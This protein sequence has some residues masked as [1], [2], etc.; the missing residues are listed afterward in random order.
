MNEIMLDTWVAQKLAK[1]WSPVAKAAK[2]V[3]TVLHKNRRVFAG[4]GMVLLIVALLAASF[5]PALADKGGNGN[6]GGKPTQGSGGGGGGQR[7][8]NGGGVGSN[9][10]G[11][12]PCSDP[13]GNENGGADK[14]G[15]NGGISPTK[16][17][18]NGSGNDL[19][20]E[21][22]NNGKGIPGH[23]KTKTPKVTVTPD[24][25]PGKTVTPTVF[26]TPTPGGSPTPTS[27]IPNGGGGTVTPTLQPGT[28]KIE[29][30]GQDVD[31]KNG[32]EIE[33]R[34]VSRPNGY[35]EFSAPITSTLTITGTQQNASFDPTGNTCVD[36]VY[37]DN[38]LGKTILAVA[39]YDGT[40]PRSLG[41]AGF[42]PTWG[43]DSS[44]GYIAFRT[45]VN[46]IFRMEPDGKSLVAL[47]ANGTNLD[48]SPSGLWV[49]YQTAQ[50]HIG[51]VW[52]Q[53]PADAF[54]KGLTSFKFE[55][56]WSCQNA[57]WDPSGDSITCNDNGLKL[58]TDTAG[59]FL[60]LYSNGSEAIMDPTTTTPFAVVLSEGKSWLVQ[61]VFGLSKLT[62]LL[63]VGKDLGA[64]V[65]PDWVAI[66]GMV[67]PVDDAWINGFLN[68]A[69]SAS[70]TPT[71]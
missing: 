48:A 47:G 52:S 29:V 60:V 45:E 9:C 67:N 22:D 24:K 58:V 4:I 41:Y 7:G 69:A 1:L 46:D 65:N 44:R 15:G 63:G 43:Y 16:D 42:D 25:T 54:K 2:I 56:A 59:T 23:C 38:S 31:A 32:R 6:G 57:R 13:D 34:L 62:S 35:P 61:N 5:S 21:D 8:G 20:C 19:D 39:H 64:G 40:N 33:V 28:C 26:V 49:M 30:Y 11:G 17:S 27:T 66:P 53:G 71:K 3:N 55:T 51:V 70:P 36:M 50:N 10:P 12:P 68:P 37:E 18:N 14:P